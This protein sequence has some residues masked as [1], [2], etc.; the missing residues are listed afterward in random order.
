MMQKSRTRAV[1]TMGLLVFIG[2]VTGFFMGAIVA[3][4]VAKKKEKPEYWKQ[5]VHKQLERLHPTDEQRRKFDARTDE[6]VKELVDLR[7]SAL[8]KVWGIVEKASAD[9]DKDLT[10]EQ[11]KTYDLIKPKK[12]AEIK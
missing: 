11:R 3:N 10:P 1:L 9:I 6:A 4:A 8:T 2:M 12:P 7:I 5:A